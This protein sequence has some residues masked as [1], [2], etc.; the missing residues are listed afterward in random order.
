M[1]S[2]SPTGFRFAALAFAVLLGVQSVWLLVAELT[3]PKL[4]R[5]PVDATAATAAAS[6]R[7]RATW[8][9]SVGL[10]RGDLWAKAAFTDADL[11]WN[12]DPKSANSA[13]S[14]KRVHANLDRAI[15]YAP[16]QAD[17]WVLFAGLASRY[18]LPNV[19]SE[20]ALMMA[21]YT[22][23]TDYRLMPFRLAIATRFTS[24]D[25]VELQEM[26]RR[27]VRLLLASRQRAAIANAY[28]S[29]SAAGKNLIKKA[30]ADYG[31]TKSRVLDPRVPKMQ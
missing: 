4:D 14:V 6:Q 12:N 24:V 19:N 10:I 29:A 7:M 17:V 28:Q 11:L 13:E 3:Q 9:A 5:L 18:A 25:D 31:T 26:I 30:I 15:A 2:F 22:G 27:D 21:Y 16:D 1:N 8:A 20:E 23:P